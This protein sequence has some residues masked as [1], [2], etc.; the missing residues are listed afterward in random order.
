[1]LDPQD[2]VAVDEAAIAATL[3]NVPHG[4]RSAAGPVLVHALLGFVDAGNIGQL[5]ADHLVEAFDVT[6]LATFDIDQ[7]L[8]YR[9]KRPHM[10]FRTDRWVDYDEPFLALEH[11]R[12]AEGTGFLLLRGAEPDAQ[13]ERVIAAV[14][15]LIRRFGVSLTV[16]FHGVP[17]GVPHTRP[18]TFSAHGTRDG[19]TE[20]YTSFFGTVKVPGS[21]AAL[22]E[23]RLGN[24]GHDALGFVIHVPHYLAQLKYVPAAV[25]ALQNIE[26][27]TGLDLATGRLDAAAQQATVDVE[28]QLADSAEVRAVVRAL[29]EQY[30]HF[31][32]RL[33]SS[34]LIADPTTIPTADELAAEFE[35]Y[36]Q[37]QGDN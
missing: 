37:Q 14:R 13:W 1:V 10:T 9:S 16:G 11:V 35:R 6:R 34:G 27:A 31:A 19:L 33:A 17:M 2:I 36:L 28:K 15:S 20:G 21:M 26:R 24:S 25:I 12:D 8:D 32:D 7:I 3:G 29:E 5:A 30:D 22:L 23:Y 4:E 18:L